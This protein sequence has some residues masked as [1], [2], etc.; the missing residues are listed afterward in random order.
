MGFDDGKKYVYGLLNN[1]LAIVSTFPMSDLNGTAKESE[2]WNVQ[3]RRSQKHRFRIKWSS[4]QIAAL[5]MIG[6]DLASLYHCPTAVELAIKW[7]NEFLPVCNLLSLSS[8]FVSIS[9][10]T[11]SVGKIERAEQ[12]F[13]NEIAS[14]AYIR[15]PST[16]LRWLF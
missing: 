11:A 7:T 6:R 8:R 15:W 3:S 1:R 13:E 16:K 5:F 9:S 2:I 12:A 10:G 14:L 4:E